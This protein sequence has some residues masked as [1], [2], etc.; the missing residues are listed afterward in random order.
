MIMAAIYL[1][2]SA[3]LKR[4]V[5]ETGSDRVNFLFTPGGSTIALI[6]QI[7]V[8]EATCAFA[9]RLREGSLALSEYSATIT[10]FNHD[11]QYDYV[12]LEIT[13]QVIHTACQL[14]ERHPLRAYDAIQLAAASLANRSLINGGQDP[15]LFICA[16]DRLNT[17]AEAEGLQTDNSNH[18]RMNPSR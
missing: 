1:D 10:A 12:L 15:L 2:T 6:S 5:S 4:Y 18:Q 7:A 3:L 8:V 13:P 14:G 17:V 16:D 9:R 11:T